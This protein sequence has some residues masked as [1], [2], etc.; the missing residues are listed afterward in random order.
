MITETIPTHSGIVPCPVPAAAGEKVVMLAG[1]PNCGKTSLFNALTGLR[2]KVANYPGVTVEKRVARL[3]FPDK[4]KATIVDLP[5]LY[6]LN[7]ESL[8]ENIATKA[9]LGLLPDEA[10]PDAVIVVADASS[11]E[12]NLLLA[13][14]LIDRGVPVLLAFTMVDLARKRGIEI[15]K[16]IISRQLKVPVVAVNPPTGEGVEELKAELKVFL[17]KLNSRIPAK[18][19]SFRSLDKTGLP[20]EDEVSRRFAWIREHI[21]D[22]VVLQDVPRNAFSAGLNRTLVHP[23]WGTLV[24]LFVM[25]FIFQAIFSWAK[26]LM[27]LLSAS[28]ESLGGLVAAVIPT[29]FLHSLLVDGIIAGV[30]SVVVFVP[31]IAI[32][33]F[34]IGLLEDS[35]YLA[36]AAFV[37]DGIM[38][39]FGL[40]GRSFIPLLSSFACAVPGILCTRSIP[41]FRDRLATILV[42]PFMT[43][44]A[45]LPVYSLLI[46]AVI[47]AVSVAGVFSLQGIVMTALYLAG[48]LSAMVAAFIL[49]K[50]ILRGQASHFVMELPPLRRPLLRTVLRNA[51]D[52]VFVFLKTAGTVIMVCSVVLWFL[53]SFPRGEIKNTF[54]GNLGRIVEPVI[55][56]L[57]MNWEIGVGLIGSF[58]AREVF[59]STLATVYNLSDE[60]DQSRSLLSILKQ[61]SETGEFSLATALALMVFYI[62]ACQCIS[63]LAVCRRESGSWKWAALMF[64]YMT[65]LAYAAAWVTYRVALMVA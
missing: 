8:D 23:V 40:Q 51:W 22:F 28:V 55:K 56:P 58:A 30:G 52:R 26:P 20:D 27:D 48:A 34:L 10:S 54:A 9:L 11:L 7:P 62:F 35:G 57:G 19:V 39:R 46:A 3:E 45:R 33:F 60:D 36:R 32:L 13:T 64:F 43:C 21:D 12:R 47:P 4:F 49:H 37:S 5:G 14:Q 2:Y 29:G 61:K 38:R 25:A 44:S 1:N 63:T 65:V 15:R 18:P 6:S 24:F 53:A 16:E 42:A 50:T 41:S 17:E 59:V 31:Q